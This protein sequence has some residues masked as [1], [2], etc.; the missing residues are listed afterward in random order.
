M[1]RW[2]ADLLLLG[3]AVIWGLAFVFQKTAMSDLGPL[4]FI[5]AR[6]LVAAIAL[7]PF[8]LLEGRRTGT[9]ARPGFYRIVGIAGGA[10][11]LGAWL[12]QWGL[13]TASVTN[14][15]FL[16]ALYVIFVPFIGW[17]WWRRPPAT[18]VWPAAAA[19]FIGTWLLGGGSI[20]SFSSGDL[21]VAVCAVFWA[22]HVVI[23]GAA[24][25]YGRPVLF[26]CV[27]FVV[28]ALLAGSGA[29]LS[30]T[31]SVP[32][33]ISAAPEI[34]YVG[35][36]SSALTFTILT[37]AVKYTPPAEAAV[38]IS[39]ESLFAALAGA[40]LLGERLSWVAWSGAVLIIAATLAVQL[41]PHLRR[42][43]PR[44]PPPN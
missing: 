23:V 38:L 7:V 18:V 31:V 2:H 20:A 40:L 39:T 3:T 19:S 29:L 28:V 8:A 10:F 36:L 9:A 44:S 21:L 42:S 26:T 37:I 17:F 34:A 33:L 16:T 35:L 24:V 12:Q 11:F 32:R 6:S 22:A 13:V 14:T 43:A 25:P 1:R 4:T 41:G 27:Q 5:T 15:G 30:E